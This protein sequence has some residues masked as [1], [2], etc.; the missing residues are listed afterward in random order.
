MRP[1]CGVFGEDAGLHPHGEGPGP[2]S[3]GQPY[4]PGTAEFIFP[5]PA[6]PKTGVVGPR[7]RGTFDGWFS[8]AERLA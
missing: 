3:G 4:R 7:V 2:P 5:G 6:H 8:D 1:A